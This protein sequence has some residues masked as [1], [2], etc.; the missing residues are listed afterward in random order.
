MVKIKVAIYDADKGYRERFADYLMNHKASEME[1]AVF[2]N[3]QFFFEA[4]DV[5]KFHLFVLG[6]GYETVLPRARAKKVPVLVL[7]ESAQSYVKE[8]IQMLDEQVVYTSKYQSMDVITQKM[9]ILANVKHSYSDRTALRRNPEI[10]GVISPVSH[11]MQILF[12]LLLARN[13][14]RAQKVLYVNL[15]EF[16][17]F[18]EIFNDT[19]YDLSD[20]I[21]QVREAEVREERLR[22][23]IYEADGF[24][25]I[26]PVL[27]PENIR[28]ISGEDV[29]R[30]LDVLTE[31]MEYQM[32]VVDIGLNVAGFAEILPVCDRI[33]SLEKRGYLHETR[34]KQFIS[35]LERAVDEA[36]VE[37]IHHLEIP[38]QAKVI[39]GGLNLL[40]QLD[41][42]DFGDFVRSVV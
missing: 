24:S 32:I 37:R 7:M 29:N 28:E 8:T 33:F 16:A 25:Y 6:G 5:D 9:Q 17:G 20:A 14:A 42:G 4:L 39:C 30:L 35:Y 13:M 3:E 36:F 26:S 41:W 19:E 11:E 1:L 2:T 15:L 18:T 27:N 22:A 12:S 34:T 10:V 40:E 38:G 23:C 31:Y 21:L